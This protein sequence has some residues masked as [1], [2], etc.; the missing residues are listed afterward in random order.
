MSAPTDEQY[1]T[2]L[3]DRAAKRF[4]YES[5]EAQRKDMDAALSQRLAKE[6]AARRADMK[7]WAKAQ[8]TNPKEQ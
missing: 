7:A 2:F 8:L 6:Q 4:G 1:M 3:Y 5:Y